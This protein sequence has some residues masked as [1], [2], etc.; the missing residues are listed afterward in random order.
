LDVAV[1]GFGKLC[2]SGR[3]ATHLMH[4]HLLKTQKGA[5]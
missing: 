4:F 2:N 3:Y 5:N 1:E